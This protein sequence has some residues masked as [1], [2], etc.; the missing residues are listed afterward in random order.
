MDEP[1]AAL[2]RAAP[3]LALLTPTLLCE[4]VIV[5]WRFGGALLG[6]ALFCCEPF[7]A[8]PFLKLVVGGSGRGRVADEGAV[9]ME[10]YRFMGDGA[11]DE[12]PARDERLV[13]DLIP[14]INSW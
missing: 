2:D 10:L 14:E 3:L 5:E 1:A 4:F 6:D 8:T 13:A 12:A 11:A 7:T 9:W